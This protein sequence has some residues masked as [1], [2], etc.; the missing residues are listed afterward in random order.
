MFPAQ[1]TLALPTLLTN[2]V[3]AA[4]E[5][6]SIYGPPQIVSRTALSAFGSR[7]L[8]KPVKLAEAERWF[9]PFESTTTELDPLLG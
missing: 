4:G 6:R 9:R 5:G 7:I 8:E 1:T 2:A 3:K